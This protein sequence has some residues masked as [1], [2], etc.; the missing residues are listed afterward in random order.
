M[1]NYSNSLRSVFFLFSLIS[2]TACSSLHKQPAVKH[3]DHPLTGKI[4]KAEG[5][6]QVSPTELL[7]TMLKSDVI[8]LGE[9]HNNT[10]HHKIQ[11]DV[12]K[13][14]VE[15]GARPAIGFEFFSRHQTSHLINH[16]NAKDSDHGGHAKGDAEKLLRLQLGWGSDR[17]QD[18]Q[19]LY[20]ILQYARE[21]KLPVFGADLSAGMRKRM[22]KVGYPGL[23]PVE[24]LLVPASDFKDENYREFMHESFVRSHCGWGDDAY[25]ARLYDAWLS[26]NEAM[27]QSIVATH[28]SVPGQPVVMI[29]GGGHTQF[30]MAVYERVEHLQADIRQINIRLQEV[31]AESIEPG[32]YLQSLEI[33]NQNYGLPYE[34]LWY[35]PSVPGR[36]DPCLE[37]NKR[38]EKSH[39]KE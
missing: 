31:V 28:E 20:S 35:T 3:P 17:E 23:T 2:V 6:V 39:K 22:S 12:I 37:F 18:W 14:L 21:N 11:L 38:K 19:R 9:N 34:Y 10:Y 30:N 16:Q 7:E 25:L 29:L 5:V 36:I 1:N 4:Y 33:N 13:K 24:K 8:Y 32:E 26:R 15:R 27:A